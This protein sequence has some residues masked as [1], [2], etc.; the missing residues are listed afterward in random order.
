MPV[1]GGIKE[2]YN[3]LPDELKRI[4]DAFAE[5]G[6]LNDRKV[7]TIKLIRTIFIDFQFPQLVDWCILQW[8]LYLRHQL[9]WIW[10][11]HASHSYG[12]Q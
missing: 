7:R 5:D 2:N 3:F 1:A 8:L 4:T 9:S 6:S 12:Q 10:Q 11:Y